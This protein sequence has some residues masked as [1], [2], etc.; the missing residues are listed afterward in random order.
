MQ[1]A[2]DKSCAAR[3]GTIQPAMQTRER[4]PLDTTHNLAC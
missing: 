2:A 1:H 4:A 3:D